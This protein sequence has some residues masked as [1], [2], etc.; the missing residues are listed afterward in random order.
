MTDWVHRVRREIG[1]GKNIFLY[2][3]IAACVLVAVGGLFAK[4][5]IS[6][7]MLFV[8]S[9]VLE[10]ILFER[11]SREEFLAK[12]FERATWDDYRKEFRE[13]LGSAR[14]VSFLAV[15]PY[16]IVRSFKSELDRILSFS[17]GKVS[18]LVVDPDE[19]AMELIH[20]GRPDNKRDGQLFLTEVTSWL[21]GYSV[22]AS[23]ATSSQSSSMLQI[24]LL[25]NKYDY[26]P[27]CIL[28]LIDDKESGGVI[29]VTLYSYK[30]A[31]PNRPSM[32][33]TRADGAWYRFFQKEFDDLW[34]A[35]TA[36]K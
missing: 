23:T 15:S 30:Q 16:G 35:G 28:T 17:D 19:R 12:L 2:I 26:V 18:F 24:R 34:S 31:D 6:S 20:S 36:L 5:Y 33:L 1:S 3:G 9:L 10:N 32:K 14:K 13:R 27:S 4:N 22:T 29:F 11:W 8:M 21:A 7:L 25:C